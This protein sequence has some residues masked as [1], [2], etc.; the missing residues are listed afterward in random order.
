MM[1]YDVYNSKN[2]I[3]KKGRGSLNV[4]FNGFNGQTV[5]KRR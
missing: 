3:S 1:W 2:P 5:K 4:E